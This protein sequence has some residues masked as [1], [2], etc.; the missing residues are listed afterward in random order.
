MAEYWT[1]LATANSHWDLFLHSR[2]VHLDIITVV[3]PTD[4]QENLYMI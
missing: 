3:L 2:A 1:Q 4:G